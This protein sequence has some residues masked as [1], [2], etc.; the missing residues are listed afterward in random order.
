MGFKKS[1][2]IK[3]GMFDINLG[4]KGSQLL[5]GEETALF[6][7]FIDAG[8]IIYYQPAAIVYHKILP[9]RLK[10]G[11]YR[12]RCFYGG[13]TVR[14]MEKV[15]FAG[16]TISK[17]PLFFIKSILINSCHWLFNLFLLNLERQ[18]YYELEIAYDLGRIYESFINSSIGI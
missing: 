14:R 17:I 3:A 11:F 6:Y 7:K 5:A 16:R 13:R 12:K 2:L 10:K 18:F 9:E 4:R 8:K 15:Q 1:E